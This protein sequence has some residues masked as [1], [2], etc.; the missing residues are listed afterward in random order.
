M[1]KVFCNLVPDTKIRVPAFAFIL[2]RTGKALVG[3]VLEHEATKRLHAWF[4]GE[5]PFSGKMRPVLEEIDLF[6]RL[7][8]LFPNRPVA[9]LLEIRK[10]MRPFVC[11][12]CG[13][14]VDW[15]IKTDYA[16]AKAAR[17]AY[18]DSLDEDL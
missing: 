12:R 13:Q 6:V 18:H 3:Y 5:A 4:P 11:P 2:L 9:R 15:R 8:E 7:R 17:E 10:G 16:Q 1:S 14:P